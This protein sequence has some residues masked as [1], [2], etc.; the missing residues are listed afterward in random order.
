MGQNQE[1]GD[2][3]CPECPWAQPLSWVRTCG[4]GC[5]SW[6]S[7]V[8]VWGGLHSPAMGSELGWGL[9]LLSSR[10]ELS[11]EEAPRRRSRRNTAVSRRTSPIMLSAFWSESVRS[12]VSPPVEC[13]LGGLLGWSLL[14]LGPFSTPRASGIYTPKDTRIAR[15]FSRSLRFLSSALLPQ[16]LDTGLY[17]CPCRPQAP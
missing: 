4:A 9:C 17:P 12:S 16:T 3:C 1:S 6:A 10:K 7:W 5:P 11:H 14:F 15:R 8:G 2:V 13:V